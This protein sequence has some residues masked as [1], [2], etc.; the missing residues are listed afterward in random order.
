MGYVYV[1]FLL[2]ADTEWALDTMNIDIINGKLLC[3]MWFQHN[4]SLRKNE[5]GDTFIKNFARSIDSK[6]LYKTLSVFGNI[7]SCTVVTNE[8]GSRGFEFVRFENSEATRRAVAKL[9]ELC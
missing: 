9:M 3:I 5:V 2:H 8:N 4:P 6:F 7:L 1:N